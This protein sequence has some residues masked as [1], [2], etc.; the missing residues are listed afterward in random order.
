MTY[1]I[2]LRMQIHSGFSS[3]SSEDVFLEKN[4]ILPFVPFT[5]LSVHYEDSDFE[6]TIKEVY[7]DITGQVFQCYCGD[8][9]KLYNAKLHNHECRALSEIVKEYTDIGWEIKKN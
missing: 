3:L 8:D 1:E 9:K 2:N 5:G 6:A 7:W 4:I